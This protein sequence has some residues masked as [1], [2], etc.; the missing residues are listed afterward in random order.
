M[1]LFKLSLMVLFLYSSG[2][3]ALNLKLYEKEKYKDVA[4]TEFQG[5]KISSSCI[6]KDKADC[7]A[8]T[9]FTGKPAKRS[10][11]VKEL[12]G[13]PAALYCADL[14]S[15]NRILKDDTGNQYDYCVFD[16]GSMVDS[17]S[18]YNKHFG[19]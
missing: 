5:A 1:K 15:M 12:L 18:I 16:D 8:W 17:W 9:A 19:S 13:N 14:K 10:K 2:S 3:Y 11:A 4:I 7:K 6:K